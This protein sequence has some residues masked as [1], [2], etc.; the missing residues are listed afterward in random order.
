MQLRYK[1]LTLQLTA[2]KTA[3]PNGFAAYPEHKLKDTALNNDGQTGCGCYEEEAQ[4]HLTQSTNSK[5]P[6]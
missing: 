5:T 1:S 2:V 4:Q 6:P 3:R